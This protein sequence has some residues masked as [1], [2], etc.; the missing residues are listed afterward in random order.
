MI[1]TNLDMYG[2][3]VTWEID[4]TAEEEE[5]ILDQIECEHNEI[6][7]KWQKAFERLGI[8]EVEDEKA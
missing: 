3:T 1:I 8:A 2:G 4:C 5:C 7:L 6:A